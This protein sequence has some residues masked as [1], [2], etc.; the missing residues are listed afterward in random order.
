MTCK[1]R[2]ITLIVAGHGTVRSHNKLKVPKI[3]GKESF[4]A[5]PS[6]K[7]GSVGAKSYEERFTRAPSNDAMKRLV[8]HRPHVGLRERKKKERGL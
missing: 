5:P 8:P 6:R 1:M 7:L 2:D 3:R 4:G